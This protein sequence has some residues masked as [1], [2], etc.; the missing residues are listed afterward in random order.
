MTEPRTYALVLCQGCSEDGALYLGDVRFLQGR[1]CCETCFND[2]RENV[3]PAISDWHDLPPVE[4]KH[5]VA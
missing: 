5:L 4:L 2:H 3:P 1:P